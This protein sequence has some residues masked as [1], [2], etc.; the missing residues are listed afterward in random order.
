MELVSRV[1]I[2]VGAS[3]LIAYVQWRILARF[4]SRHRLRLNGQHVI[5]LVIG[6]LL[7][8][9]IAIVPGFGATGHIWGVVVSEAI[10]VGPFVL[11]WSR[12]ALREWKSLTS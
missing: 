7:L 12:E 2:C 11:W 10:I 4:G 9:L 3:S 1:L 8:A 6:V 5:V